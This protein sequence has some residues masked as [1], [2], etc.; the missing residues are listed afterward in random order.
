M[1]LAHEIK[2]LLKKDMRLEWRNRYAFNGIV[3]YMLLIVF[4]IFLSFQRVDFKLWNTLLWIIL[5]FVSVNGIAKSFISENRNRDIYYYSIASA[6]SVILSKMIYNLLLMLLITAIGLAAYS[7]V[8]GFP[9]NHV[10]PYFMVIFLGTTGFSVTF[11]MVAGIASRAGNNPALMAILSLPIFMPMLILIL[12]I[13][14]AGFTQVPDMQVL[15]NLGLLAS[16]D[17]LVLGM[18]LILFPYIWRD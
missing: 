3:L 8:L 5:L 1:K 9:V 15:K 14:E 17:L 7:F 18:S 16:I 12:N 6:Q 2:W 4:I 13:S 10:I 11:T